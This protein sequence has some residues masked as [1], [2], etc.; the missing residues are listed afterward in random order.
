MIVWAGIAA[1]AAVIQTAILGIA[2]IYALMQLKEA[3]RLRQL[4]VLTS[5]R[6]IDSEESRENR[7]K[8][9]N[10][11]PDNLASSLTVEQDR[12]VDRVVVEYDEIGKLAVNGFIDFDL[13]ASYYGE[14]TERSWKRTE[15]WIQKERMR[16]NNAPYVPY[17]EELAK[18]CIEYN[19][20]RHPEGRE[21]FRRAVRLSRDKR[22]YRRAKS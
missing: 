20:Q 8:L 10:T 12:L 22:P 3:R 17:F 11:L 19:I 15:P 18:R 21:P 4:S 2:A 6:Y 14:S 7:Y 5:L 9:F 13:I 16:R 1:I